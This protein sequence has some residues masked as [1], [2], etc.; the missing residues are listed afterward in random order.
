MEIEI[1]I[2]EIEDLKKRV[3]RIEE[4]LRKKYLEEWDSFEV[5]N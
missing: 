1:T 5:T 3:K 2:E 4:F